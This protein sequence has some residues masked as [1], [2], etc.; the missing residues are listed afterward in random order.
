MKRKTLILAGI[1]G[2]VA[3]FLSISPASVR[4]DYK[5]DYYDYQEMVTLLTNLET[6][7]AA[8]TPNVYSLQIIGYSYQNNPIYAVKF[9]DNPGLEQ[10][11]KPVVVIDSGTHSNEWL[12]V[13]SNLNFIQYLFN[14][15]YTSGHPDHA[16]VVDLVN[17]FEIWIIPMINPDGRIRDDLN[18]GDPSS[19]WTATTYHADDTCWMARERTGSGLPG[20]ARRKKSGR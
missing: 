17:N 12:P 9:S 7:A 4:A 19:F 10:E 20:Q 11:D 3:L 5:D 15:Y 13:E 14:A 18:H 16:E 2:T 8:K 6:Q 1:I